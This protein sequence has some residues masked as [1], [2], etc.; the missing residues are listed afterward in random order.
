MSRSLKAVNKHYLKDNYYKKKSKDDV[1]NNVFKKYIL[2]LYAYN[3]IV[4]NAH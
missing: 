3:S 2:V 1:V 4:R